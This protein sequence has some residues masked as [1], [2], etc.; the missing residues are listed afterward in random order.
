MKDKILSIIGMAIELQKKGVDVNCSYLAHCNCFDVRIF[1]IGWTACK[2]PTIIRL[3]NLSL[4]SAMRELSSIEEYL[5][6]F[7]QKVS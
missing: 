5:H 1:C 2:T 4:D 7:L 3:I 6:Q